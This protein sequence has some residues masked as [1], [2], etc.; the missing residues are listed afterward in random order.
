M[1]ANNLRTVANT[2][3]MSTVY[4]I[5]NRGWSVHSGQVTCRYAAPS[6]GGIQFWSVFMASKS[7]NNLITVAAGREMSTEHQ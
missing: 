2:R 5:A 7:A 1:A 3:E 6:S 4:S